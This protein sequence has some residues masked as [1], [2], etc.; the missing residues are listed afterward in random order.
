MD[1]FEAELKKG[2][3]DE[4]KQLLTD[5]EQCF[6]QLEANPSDQ[7]LLEQIFRLAHN[8]K[9][10]SK[11]VGF[12]ALGMFTHEFETYLLKIKKGE[13][14]GSPEVVSLLLKCND[15]LKDSVEKLMADLGATLNPGDLVEQLKA[16]SAGGAAT[17]SSPAP[18][19][20]APSE[21]PAASGTTEAPPIPPELAAMVDFPQSPIATTPPAA[22]AA[23]APEVP[24][25]PANKPPSPAAGAADESIRV[26]LSR[27]DK[28]VDYVG[29]M[30]ILQTVLKEQ[31]HGLE[32]LLL[33]K[34]LQ[35]LGKVTKEVQDLS[36][37]L[38][39]V[40][41]KQ[42][43][44][45][46][47]RIVRDTAE[48]LKKKVKLHIQGED[49]EVDKTV[50]E[51]IGDPLVHLIRNA[52]DHGIESR[53][54]RTSVGKNEEGN[55]YLRA[56]HQGGKLV[57]QIQD[58]GGGI[59]G[60]RLL[61]KAIEKGLFPANSTLSDK[62]KIHLIFHPGFSTKEQ[63]TEV[64]GR[65]V[66]MDVVKTNIEKLQGEIN[67]ETVVG[68]GTTFSI[69]LPLTLAIIEGMVV[70][71]AGERYVVPLSHVHETVRLIPDNVKPTTGFGEALI[72]R[73][74]NIPLFRLHH[75]LGKK[76]TTT[77]VDGI[78]IIVRERGIPLAIAVDDIV[79][80]QEVV[81]KN[82]G[83]ELQRY[84][85]VAGGAILGDGKPSLILELFDLAN[86]NGAKL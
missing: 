25:K 34:T 38:R 3:L 70:Y 17:G 43:F 48:L 31:T 62:Q 40:P 35:Q 7:A 2:F 51:N 56:F 60:D 68:K 33:R 24:K 69:S 11:A 81:V 53:E 73:E 82:L 84:P 52:V 26:S 5:V 20:A 45:K 19:T 27:V 23:V 29:E 36:M 67:I 66:G 76:K 77:T 37:G 14:P 30:V 64:S 39:M 80:Q 83:N 57:I 28:L 86:R 46:M 18:S 15:Y 54:K 75:L 4:A 22:P 6:L 65:G 55:I 49:T 10:S 59:D 42:T 16:S 85:G 61:G 78:A 12:D 71:S 50:L 21:S 13:I 8:L 63:V 9:G 79:G 47:Q 44:Q 1:A 41:L 72:L 74:E 58:D 32:S